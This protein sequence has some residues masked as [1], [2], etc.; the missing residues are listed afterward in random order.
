MISLTI[1]RL[2]FMITDPN[3]TD[4]KQIISK[5]ESK[6]TQVNYLR[7]Y[8]SDYSATKLSHFFGIPYFDNTYLLPLAKKGYP[9]PLILQISLD[10]LS[11]DIGL[12]K[13]GILQFFFDFDNFFD[14]SG[15]ESGF[16]RYIP[17]VDKT[18][19]TDIKQEFETILN[20]KNKEYYSA[21]SWLNEETC[22]I[23]N[24]V[25]CGIETTKIIY[26]YYQSYFDD[27]I[28]FDD[29]P[30]KE[31]EDIMEFYNEYIG[32]RQEGIN[33]MG[34]L[35]LPC[36]LYNY[37]DVNINEICLLRTGSVSIDRDLVIFNISY[38]ISPEDL[39][40]LKFDSV[41]TIASCNT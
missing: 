35:A 21:F 27:G 11:L 23:I 16:V 34:G 41:K 20:K 18:R 8:N 15:D 26:P 30:S 33:Y 19:L 22:N 13:T 25:N 6:A 1:V 4:I 37:F 39:K 17:T 31:V 40:K 5:L 24:G 7:L 28:F 3:F 38:C 2:I 9:L 12:P 36:D 29:F 10:R 14:T 32:P